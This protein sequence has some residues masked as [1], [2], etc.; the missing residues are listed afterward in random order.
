[1]GNE[2]V[3]ILEP[4]AGRATI[5]SS[6]ASQTVSSDIN[7]YIGTGTTIN[8]A[9]PTLPTYETQTLKSLKSIDRENS[10]TFNLFRI[11]HHSAVDGP[12]RR[13]VIQFAGCSIRC[14]GCYVPE[15][16]EK[17]NGRIGLIDDIISEIDSHR[18]QHDGVTILGG[19]P[20]DQSEALE[21]LVSK[22]KAKD[23]HIT[24]YTGFTLEILS[25]RNSPAVDNILQN[26]DLL[27][28]GQYKRELANNAGEYRG[29]SNQRMVIKP[30]LRVK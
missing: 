30:G 1:M 9:R 6:R 20:F 14:S 28:D 24:I 27:I 3:F 26:A 18:N 17:T 8:C 25:A 10:D 23:Y 15:T 29:S 12:G 2:I 7:R 13:S 16:H 5:E 21:K 4:D 19:E 22:L 11:Y